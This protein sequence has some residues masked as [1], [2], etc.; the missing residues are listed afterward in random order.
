MVKGSDPSRKSKGHPDKHHKGAKVIVRKEPK[1]KS[2]KLKKQ[3]KPKKVVKIKRVPFQ[4]DTPTT[5]NLLKELKKMKSQLEL[6]VKEE[7]KNA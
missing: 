4:K 7:H 3:K 2:T 6:K 5:L 1:V